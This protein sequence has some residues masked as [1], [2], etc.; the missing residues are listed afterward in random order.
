MLNVLE[1]VRVGL[2]LPAKRSMESYSKEG[3]SAIDSPAAR[4]ETELMPRAPGDS[5]RGIKDESAA[6]VRLDLLLSNKVLVLDTLLKSASS[7]I[8]MG[9]ALVVCED[10]PPPS[11]E[12]PSSAPRLRPFVKL[13]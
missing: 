8:D 3:S 6:A 10:V 12:E 5:G 13:A 11:D 7:M 2:S 9:R 1:R 4:N